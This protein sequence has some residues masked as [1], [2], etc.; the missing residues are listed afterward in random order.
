MV[1]KYKIIDKIIIIELI[2][3]LNMVEKENLAKI[4]NVS[5][6]LLIKYGSWE[7]KMA[8]IMPI[9]CGGLEGL[10]I[11]FLAVSE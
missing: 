8:G 9:G 7:E 3:S 1:G 11:S 5:H 10:L 2:N 6:F 4:L